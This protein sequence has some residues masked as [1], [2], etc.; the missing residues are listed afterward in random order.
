MLLHA[1][2]LLVL[3]PLLRLLPPLVLL[4]LAIALLVYDAYRPRRTMRSC[5][6]TTP[7]DMRR[8]DDG[9][10]DGNPEDPS[11]TWGYLR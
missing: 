1:L 6:D 8:A 3:L 5:M 10:G 11:M 9:R 4:V 7:I 2:V